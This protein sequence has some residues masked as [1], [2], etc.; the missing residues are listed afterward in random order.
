MRV[1]ADVYQMDDTVTDRT[2]NMLFQTDFRDHFSFSRP[3]GSS[4]TWINEIVLDTTCW[5]CTQW[6]VI[7]PD[8]ICTNYIESTLPFNEC[9]SLSWALDTFAVLDTANVVIIDG[10]LTLL[11]SFLCG[12]I[13][14][15]A[16][17]TITIED[18]VYLVQ[19]MFVNGPDPNP[20]EAADV[21]CSGTL[22]IGDLVYMVG[23]MFTGGPEPCASCP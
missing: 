3:D 4:I 1:L 5:Q 12:N 6:I 22:D 9:D 2:V 21:D 8:T 18:L 10:S 15:D 17:L 20:I 19:Y 16:G 23:Y 11:F 7:P 14:G 13:D